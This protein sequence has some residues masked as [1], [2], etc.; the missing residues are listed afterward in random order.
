MKIARFIK[1]LRDTERRSIGSNIREGGLSRFLHD[2]SQRPSQDEPFIPFHLR[3]LDKDDV[4]SVLCPRQP[5]RHANAIL[6][7]SNLAEEFSRTQ[8]LL[9]GSL[10]D[11]LLR[12]I[13]H[14][15]FLGNFP[16]DAR[17]LPFQIPDPCFSRIFSDD[18]VNC[19]RSERKGT[20]LQPIFFLLVR[21]QKLESDLFLLLLGISRQMD[22]LH[23]IQ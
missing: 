19:T 15:Y 17:N 22:H 8:E 18:P 10:M 4:S 2:L 14:G 12:N 5:R 9:N 1:I 7:L 21:D 16:T 23:P 11:A 13:S 6:L 3:S 20:V